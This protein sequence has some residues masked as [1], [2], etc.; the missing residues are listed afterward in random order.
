MYM[1]GEMAMSGNYAE[2][3]GNAEWSRT[4]HRGTTQIP[5]GRPALTS[6]APKWDGHVP[7]TARDIHVGYFAWI[8]AIATRSYVHRPASVLLRTC[9]PSIPRTVPAPLRA[10]TR[11]ALR[12]LH[13]PPSMV[14]TPTRPPVEPS[15]PPLSPLALA[16]TAPPNSSDSYFSAQAGS[17][18]LPRHRRTSGSS[19]SKLSEFSLDPPLL[20]K[21]D[22]YAASPDQ[23]DEN[24]VTGVRHVALSVDAR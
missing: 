14:V 11:P 17:R 24:G 23:V 3:D 20:D 1:K 2:I 21:T 19:F 18:P 7:N 22:Q 8:I 4:L 13:T 6:D 9:S 5:P 12:R 10:L 16:S 15:G